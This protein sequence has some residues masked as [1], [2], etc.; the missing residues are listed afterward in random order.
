MYLY[1]LKPLQSSMIKDD[2]K[3]ISFNYKHNN[4]TFAIIFYNLSQMLLTFVKTS[5]KEH[6]TLVIEDDFSITGML[7]EEDYKTLVNMLGLKFEKGNPFKPSDFL[8]EFSKK[9]PQYDAVV[10]SEIKTCAKYIAKHIEDADK[11][12]FVR[13]MPHNNDGKHVSVANLNKTALYLGAKQ[14]KLCKESN[15]SSC[16][17]IE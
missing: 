3:A 5:T 2:I 9:I 14:A 15:V 7:D 10:K 6:F 1:K 17:R 8:F 12:V 11:T 13:F 4:T 16:W